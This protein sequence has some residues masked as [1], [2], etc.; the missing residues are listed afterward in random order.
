MSVGWSEA[1]SLSDDLLEDHNMI[2]RVPNHQALVA[3]FGL[4][5]N[6]LL[7]SGHVQSGVTFAETVGR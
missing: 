1:R 4:D 5:Q 2:S 3:G 7:D 6:V